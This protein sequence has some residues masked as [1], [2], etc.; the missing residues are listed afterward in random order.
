VANATTAIPAAAII[1]LT[2]ISVLLDIV[3]LAGRPIV[4]AARPNPERLLP[5]GEPGA[6]TLVESE[7]YEE[8]LVDGREELAV[9]S[10]RG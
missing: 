8:H 10:R 2:R 5:P 7:E 3:V 6:T 4:A 1:V 9:S